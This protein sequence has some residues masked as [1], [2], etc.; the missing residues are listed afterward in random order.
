MKFH[1][2]CELF[3]LMEG[4]E[5]ER[6]SADIKANGLLESIWT[7]EGQILDGRNRWLACKDAGVE[8][9]F[10]E[11]KGHDAVSF[12]VSMNIERRHLTPSQRAC[13]GVEILPQ[14]EAEA[15][16]RERAGK[17]IDPT[18]KLPQG[19]ARVAAAAIVHVAPRYVSDA[20]AIKEEALELFEEM[21]AGL[22]TIQDAKKDLHKRHAKKR[23]A[24]QV[25]EF[26]KAETKATILRMDIR[27]ATPE[28]LG[29]EAGEVDAIITDPPYPGEFLPLFGNL[30][31]FA[32][33]VLRDGG[34]LIAMSG[35]AH[36]PEVFRLLTS[37]P[38]LIYQWT[39][40]YLT[41]GR[42]T[43]L[44]GKP[45]ASNWKPLIWLT[46]GAYH[47]PR[48]GD[49]FENPAPDKEH[50]DWGQGE[51]GMAQIIDRMTTPGALVVDPFLGGGTT[52]VCC[53][54][55][56]RRFIG[57]DLDED[58]TKIARARIAKAEY[59]NSAA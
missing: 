11:Y 45:I 42:A 41:P 18:A 16:K 52:G 38:R 5:F 50:H 40:A 23:Q 10:R 1:P 56:Q 8:P 24:A 27:D 21:K 20:K 47:G 13:I 2:I 9:E 53:V 29:I 35:E 22:T 19:E 43:Q 25:K 51:I 7:Y 49:I 59:D 37:D 17:K 36:L 39:M 28:K 4:E 57:F 12:V 32:G 46:K 14:Y 34:S 30:A 44:R 54:R 3:P 48:I 6:L 58:T 15:E 26:E 31:K 55:S 33:D